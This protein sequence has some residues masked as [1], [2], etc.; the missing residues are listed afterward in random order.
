MASLVHRGSLATLEESYEALFSWIEKNNYQIIGSVREVFL[1][2]GENFN[3]LVTEVQ[4]PINKI[5]K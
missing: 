2:Y 3:P 1:E 4:V 5:E